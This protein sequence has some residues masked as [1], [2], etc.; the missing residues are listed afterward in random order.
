MIRNEYLK[1]CVAVAIVALALVWSAGC[2]ETPTENAEL[3]EY[4][5]C[6]VETWHFNGNVLVASG[7]SILL[8][9]AYGMADFEHN[10]PLTPDSKFL[11]GSATKTMTAIAVM[12]LIDD[13]KL[14]LD[15]KLLRYLPDYR[16][17]V[18]EAVTVHHLLSH[19]SGIPDLIRHAGFRERVTG[20]I[21]VDELTGFIE[22]QALEF[23][24]GERYTYSSS[25][26]VLLGKIIEV[27]T[28]GTWEEYIRTNVTEPAGML[29]TGVFVDYGSRDDFAIGYSMS[30][31]PR[32]D[33][34]K[35]P[36]IHP[37][38]GY[39][40]GALAST[41][42][43]LHSLHRALYTESL[44]P[45]ASIELMLTPQTLFY[46][47]GWLVDDPGDH[48]LAA[49]G[50]GAPGFASMFQRWVDD[51]VCVVVLSNNALIP[52]HTI[53]QGLAAIALGEEYDLPVTK[54]PIG[55]GLEQLR[56]YVGTYNLDSAD[57]RQI[58]LQG[59]Q[60]VARRMNGMPMR[61]HPE[62]ADRFY[63]AHDHMSTLEFLR[64]EDGQVYAHVF[65]QAFARDTAWLADR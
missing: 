4:M 42:D 40:A 63:F 46:G 9:E 14:N 28:G 7:D 39:A 20:E 54:T 52:V 30:P 34:V 23:E 11:I 3:R 15:D 62:A 31:A 8:R 32:H 58:E 45:S 6:A 43:D 33:T 22:P 17:E 16:S 49:H 56:Q 57:N 35:A 26:Y 13:G 44:L 47:Y 24:P 50:G 25:N 12:Q 29:N 59:E 65:R 55:V 53:A 21:S 48:R 19:Q 64:D 38:C 27:V 36:V 2:G 61:I 10:R 37:S 5:D 1:H 51:S 60:L 18:G 41:V